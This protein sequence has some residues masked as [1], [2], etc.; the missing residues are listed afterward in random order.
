MPD[1]TITVTSA[2]NS[3]SVLRHITNTQ[4]TDDSGRYEFN[5]L[6]G[7]YNVTVSYPQ[8]RIEKLGGFTLE[9]GSPTGTLNDYLLYGQPLMTDPVVYEE[10]KKIHEKMRLSVSAAGSDSAAALAAAEQAQQA[11]TSAKKNAEQVIAAHQKV[12]AAHQKVIATH[13]EV[14][15][16]QQAAQQAR[17]VAVAAAVDAAAA[18]A[19]ETEKLAEKLA[20]DGSE[21]TGHGATTIANVLDSHGATTSSR[22]IGFGPNDIPDL[23]TDH[24]AALQKMLN[25]YKYIVFDTVV[26]CAGTVKTGGAGQ[27]ISATGIGELRPVGE[28]MSKKSLLVLT[29]ER[30]IVAKML[31]TNPLLLKSQTGGRQCAV[32]VRADNCTVL[33]STFINQLSGVLA[34]STYAPAH[35][36]ILGN[37]FID[38]LGA[39][40]GEGRDDS[41][42]GED[43]GD[44]VTIWGSSSIIANNHAE[45]RLGED[46][47]IAFHAEYPVSKPTNAREIDGCHTLMIG[48]YARGSF[49]R[50]FVMEGITNGLM[51]NNISA[52]GATWWAVAVI[53]CT[54]VKTDNRI[55]WDNTGSTAGAKWSPI[56]G[57]IAAV[58]FNENVSF[59]DSVKFS[60]DAQGYGFVIATQTGEHVIDLNVSLSCAGNEYATY[61]LRPKLL[62]MQ[63]VKI[64]GAEN[65]HRFI[66]ANSKT[67]FTPT[68]YDTDGHVNTASK[69]V[70]MDTGIN[71]RWIARN[72]EYLSAGDTAFHLFNM[73]QLFFQNCSFDAKKYSVQTENTKSIKITGCS[74]NSNVPLPVRVD[75]KT[76][77]VIGLNDWF[78]DGNALTV[79]FVYTEESLTD[80]NSPLNVKHKWPGRVI[81]TETAQYVAAGGAPGSGWVPL[82]GGEKIT[83]SAPPEPE[84]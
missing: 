10:I 56:R 6:P 80:I 27:V 3:L 58:N 9:E 57:A 79:D 22:G 25:T 20:V 72:C 11:S 13:Q 44:A 75:L 76:T 42:Y 48:N 51:T 53:Q 55:Y 69:C 50:H 66:G 40:D 34:T 26:N 70:T 73:D 54:N 65:G 33:D 64:D 29:H 59:N 49:R 78:F 45:C 74:S 31:F 62:R 84:V 18:A 2:N 35:T 63:G 5:L 19:I 37:R 68:V 28:A 32:E 8:G 77:G 16:A 4:K 36:K 41:S 81:S 52:G 60:T 14:I 71:G 47:R 38:H 46:A 39:G 43:R 24:S 61:L 23:K 82:S 17:E 67:G 7:G 83:P 1:V 15:A 21:I 30:C 12:I